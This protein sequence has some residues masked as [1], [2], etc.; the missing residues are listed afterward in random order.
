MYI[1]SYYNILS[2]AV[3]ALITTFNIG[4]V[5]SSG[6]YGNVPFIL[7]D[8]AGT[9]NAITVGATAS[10]T[11][12]VNPYPNETGKSTLRRTMASYSSRGPAASIQNK[13]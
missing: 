10:T 11:S 4:V 7:G 3:E 2:K 12:E 5:I 8:F 6:N 1:S 9:P 13:I